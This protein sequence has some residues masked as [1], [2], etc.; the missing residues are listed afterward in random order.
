[1]R[2]PSASA[3]RRSLRFVLLFLLGVIAGMCALLLMVGDEMDRLHLKARKL[4]NENIQYVEQ[5]I[6]YQEIRKNLIQKEKK[7]VEKIEIH[8]QT[9]DEFVGTELEKKL[10]K[11]LYFLKGKPL[12]YVASFHEGIGIMLAERTYT[13]D[14]RTYLLHLSTLVI[15]PSLHFYIRVEEKR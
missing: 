5:L 10:L 6:E 3:F 1:M 13:I 2:V 12:D 14:G 15:S 8:L 9:Q 4:E 7:V 11:D